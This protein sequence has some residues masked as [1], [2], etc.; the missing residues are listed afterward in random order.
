MSIFLVVYDRGA[1]ELLSIEKFD[2][3]QR[4]VAE[5]ERLKAEL[6]SVERKLGRE[7]ILLEAATEDD[8]RLTH[9]RYFK[10]LSELVS[11]SF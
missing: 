3:S 7:V 5:A 8:L 2:D 6:D 11:S 10:N 1:G 9:A 4:N